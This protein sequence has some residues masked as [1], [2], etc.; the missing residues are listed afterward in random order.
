MTRSAMSEARTPALPLAE[1]RR[2]LAAWVSLILAFGI[3]AGQLARLA[4]LD[5]PAIL[6]APL[7]AVGQSL[8]RPDIVDRNGRLL[9]TDISAPSIFADPSAILDLDETVESL[10]GV[11]EG[12]DARRLRKELADRTKQFVW[13][14]RAVHPNA[15]RVVHELGL[16]GIY[17][18]DELHRVY[19][20]AEITGQVLGYTDV[21]NRGQA[22]VERTIDQKGLAELAD[23]A[24]T[25]SRPPVALSLDLSVQLGLS[26]VLGEAMT[27]YQASGAAGIVL[28]VATG[29]VLAQTSLPDYP[30]GDAKAAQDKAHI[31]R[32]ANGTYELGSVFKTLTLAMAF[33]AGTATPDKQY[34][35]TRPLKVGRYEIDDLHPQRRWLSAEE[36]LLY[37]SNVGAAQMALEVGDRAEQAFLKRLGLLDPLST[38]LGPTPAPQVPKPWSKA[39]TMTISFGH[40][41]AV[42]PLQFAAAVASVV[43]GGTRIVPTYLQQE[44]KPGPQVLLRK[45]TATE[46]RGLLRKNVVD[47]RG[48]GSRAAVAGY[49][50]GGKT[51]TADIAG[52]GGYGSS[53][54]LTSFLAVF[55]AAKPRY[56]TYVM[57]FE[58]KATE[59]TLGQRTAGA[60]AAPTTAKLIERI[61][62]LLGLKPEYQDGGT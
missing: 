33:D 43:N 55:P 48:T 2:V 4:M 15:A 49:A 52:R 47:K 13:I 18:R 14:K 25:A 11:L 1:R 59:A 38:E 8:S 42:T 61:A 26:E 46:L 30:A 36:V 45:E 10:A 62:P 12:I 40:G 6:T 24:L 60:N 9:A 17:Q 39:S 16:P 22:G 5:K 54:V 21:D 29:E 44:R 19:P 3:V 27:A 20:A 58:P 35:A 56:L 34:D 53:G 37:S 57:L 28:D 41:L 50:V 7:K 51:G 32:I 23:L 31:D